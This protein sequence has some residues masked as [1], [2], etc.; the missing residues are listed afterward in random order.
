[1]RAYESLNLTISTQ[2]LRAVFKWLRMN[3]DGTEKSADALVFGDEDG[4]QPVSFRRAWTMAVLKAHGVKPEWAKETGTQGAKKSGWKELTAECREAFK[5]INLHW[6]D[7]RHE[8]ASRLVERGAP[9]AQ[10]R[11]LLGH[12]SIATTERYDNQTWEALQAAAGR[13]ERGKVFEKPAARFRHTC[14]RH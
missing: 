10:V 5:T 2:R 6:H 7:L 14:V 1:M 11:D 4:Q 13:L 3:D 12:A 8:Y 9:L